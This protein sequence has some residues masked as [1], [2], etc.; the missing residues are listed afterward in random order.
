MN[1]TTH[2]RSQLTQ[3][4][5]RLVRDFKDAAWFAN[6]SMIGL[7]HVYQVSTVSS[8]QMAERRMQTM[9]ALLLQMIK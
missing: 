9:I 3:H 8:F 1:K 7:A 6:P 4:A 2:L 5:P